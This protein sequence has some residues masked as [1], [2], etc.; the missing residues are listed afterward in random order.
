MYKVII[1]SFDYLKKN[2]LIPHFLFLVFLSLFA[3]VLELASI[4]SIPIL[5]TALLGLDSNSTILS[6]FEFLKEIDLYKIAI[7]VLFLF[8]LKNIFLTIIFYLENRFIEKISVLIKSDIYK[9]LIF[10]PYSKLNNFS[11]SKNTSLVIEAGSN[12]SSLFGLLI[13]IIRESLLLIVIIIF[14]ILTIPIYTIVILFLFGGIIYVFYFFTNKKL[15]KIGQNIQNLFKSSVKNIND[16]FISLDIL[17]IYKK[18]SFFLNLFNK[19]NKEKEKNQ[20]FFN[21]INKLP[22]VLIEVISII[23][24][25]TVILIFT[26][27]NFTSTQIIEIISILA[28]SVIRMIPLSNSLTTSLIFFKRIEYPSNE[29]LKILNTNIKLDFESSN[30]LNKQHRKINLK[31]KIVLEIKNLSFS[32]NKKDKILKK[33]NLKLKSGDFVALKG[34]SGFGKTTLLKLILGFLRPNSGEIKLNNN[35]INSFL[36]EWYSL[37][38]YVPQNFVILND[39]IR[40]NIA[41]G[42]K[43]NEIDNKKV[44]DILKKVGLYEFIFKRKKNIYE[45]INPRSNNFSGGQLQRIAI[46]RALYFNPKILIMDEPTNSLDKESEK[47]IVMM[48]KKLKNIHIKIIVS[49]SNEV[50]KIC[51]KEVTFQK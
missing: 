7:F 47:K 3:T 2:L 46:A 36:S 51:N 21:F 24:L 19:I 12:Y 29:V 30:D 1:K 44:K 27:I 40:R 16:N 50:I 5:F 43:E 14:L 45:N 32:Y 26:K 31:K 22:K 33:L 34:Y 9:K 15:K 38:G 23:F 35:N 25:V 11:D 39:Q 13:N 18:E 48:L 8:I 17:K 10:F 6:N 4:G 20:F 49:H 37:I 28:V 42:C 41:F